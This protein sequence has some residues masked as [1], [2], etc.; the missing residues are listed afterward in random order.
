MHSL[1]R[2]L[3]VSVSVP[4]V[5]FFGVTIAMFD[6]SFR[7]LSERSLEALLNAQM[8][9]LIAAASLSERLACC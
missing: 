5:V 6:T 8:V 4:L 1:S 3:L 7:D 9:A 2:R